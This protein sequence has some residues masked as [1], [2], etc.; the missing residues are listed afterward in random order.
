[1]KLSLTYVDVGPQ[2]NEDQ[3]A[4]FW[5]KDPLNVLDNIHEKLILLDPN[6]NS[7]WI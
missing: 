7:L 5:V 4:E 6:K 1:M 2:D 3:F